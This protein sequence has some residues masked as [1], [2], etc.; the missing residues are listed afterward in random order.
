MGKAASAWL[1]PG[2]CG[3]VLASVKHATY[4]L[5]ESG[6]LIWL[7]SAESAMH[8]R[9]IRWPVPLPNLAVETAFLVQD[10]S[11]D[12]ACG[13]KL[14]LRSSQ[15]WEAPV[16]PIKNILKHEVIPDNLLAMFETFLSDESPSGFGAFIRP[17]LLITRQKMIDP[18][19]QLEDFLTRSAWAAVEKITRACLRHDLPSVLKEADTLIGLG[20]GL[21]PSG[22]DFLGGLFFAIF[23]LSY[24]Y[25]TILFNL[26]AN[27]PEWV[28]A[29]QS[30]TN[31][32]SFTLLKDNASGHGLEPLSRLGIALLTTQMM[33]N[34][35]S[36]ASDLVKVGHS[37]GWSLLAGF[38]TGLL[39][40]TSN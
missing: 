20:E 13:K 17:I 2:R 38:V 7:A 14:D 35:I 32:I 21:T 12:L 9:C 4:L 8:R 25:P 40:A 37:T 15:V 33:E 3:K 22:D 24:S 11:I 27:L 23:L 30:C 10:R 26:T 18:G 19:I 36:A 28:D 5:M 31:Q 34:A 39:L 6:E 16:V 29:H 1:A